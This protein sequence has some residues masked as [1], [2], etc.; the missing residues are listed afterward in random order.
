M[1]VV[2]SGTVEFETEKI[3]VTFRAKPREGVGIG[4]G[5]ITNSFLALGGTLKSPRIT[6]DPASSAV[7]TGAAVAT[8]GLS[9]LARGV[10]D[11]LS[12]AS[13][14]CEPSGN[15]VAD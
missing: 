14:I 4:L 13:S 15:K 8:G 1:M 3:G 7:A 5:T 2:A 10:W 12:A 6:I 9:L 11:R